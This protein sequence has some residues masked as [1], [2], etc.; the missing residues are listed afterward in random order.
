MTTSEY[1]TMQSQFGM[2]FMDVMECG[3][4]VGMTTV[5][6]MLQFASA[7]FGEWVAKRV[8]A[9]HPLGFSGITSE[10]CLGR[11]IFIMAVRGT[12]LVN[13]AE[14]E[15]LCY[16]TMM[17]AYRSAYSDLTGRF[18]ATGGRA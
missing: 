10:E 8:F 2:L 15:V 5:D 6:D 4:Q 17:A 14:R 11:E 12:P 16:D 7:H 18:L 3:A 9:Q 13:T 1:L